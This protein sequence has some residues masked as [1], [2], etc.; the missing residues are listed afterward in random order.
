MNFFY[1][2][3]ELYLEKNIFRYKYIVSYCKCS[4]EDIFIE[5]LNKNMLYVSYFK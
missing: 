1:V 2:D 3:N 5:K 4:Y